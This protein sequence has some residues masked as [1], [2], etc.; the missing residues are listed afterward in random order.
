MHISATV[1]IKTSMCKMTRQIINTVH[2]LNF[3]CYN[4]QKYFED[5]IER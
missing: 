3:N 2:N 1:K 4:I 5:T